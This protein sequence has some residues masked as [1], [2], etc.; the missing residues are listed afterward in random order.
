MALSADVVRKFRNL[1]PTRQL[2]AKAS[3]VLYRGA[4]L[5]DSSGAARALNAGDAFMGFN[6]GAQTTGGSADG[7]VL[8]ESCMSGEVY[9]SV[10]N[11]ASIDDHGITVYASADG[12]FT[13]ASTGNSAVGKI[14][15]YD[16]GTNCWVKFEAASDRSI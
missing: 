11:V 12:T 9:L 5:G 16:T 10:T 14:V 1:A 7:S 6:V 2:P 3:A 15:Q 13:T 8:V 4:A